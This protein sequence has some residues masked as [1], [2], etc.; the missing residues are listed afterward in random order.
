MDKLR[1]ITAI[2]IRPQSSNEVE[3]KNQ[4]VASIASPGQI[5][6]LHPLFFSTGQTIK[7]QKISQRVFQFDYSFDSVTRSSSGLNT[8]T[9]N[10]NSSSNEGTQQNIYLKIGYSMIDSAMKGYHCSLF[11]YGKRISSLFLFFVYLLLLIISLMIF[12]SILSL[13]TISFFLSFNILRSNWIWKNSYNGWG[14]RK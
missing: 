1:I 7:D 4:I 12:I 2:R 11:A 5:V 14:I 10:S 9:N 3:S 8:S 13:I 6:L